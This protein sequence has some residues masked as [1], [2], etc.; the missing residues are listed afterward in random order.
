[1]IDEPPCDLPTPCT[2]GYLLT[3]YFD[4]TGTPRR[5][6]FEQIRF[7]ATAEHE[8]EKLEEFS[9]TTGQVSRFSSG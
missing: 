3:R 2:I 6:F 7:F 9:S 1:M 8:R 5:H 4:I